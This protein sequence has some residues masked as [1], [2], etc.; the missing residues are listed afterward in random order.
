MSAGH[1][2]TVEGEWALVQPLKC[3]Y[4]FGLQYDDPWIHIVGIVVEAEHVTGAPHRAVLNEFLLQVHGRYLG[5][6]FGYSDDGSL[7]LMHDVY[8]GNATPAH[9]G[10][11]LKQLDVTARA[12]V[13]LMESAL[14]DGI[15]P[16]ADRVDRAFGLSR[17]HSGDQ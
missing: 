6:R 4:S 10:R 2:V 1:G 15:V 9:I 8:P 14:R 5:C 7:A 11:L 13:P 17:K 3:E 12:L 16:D